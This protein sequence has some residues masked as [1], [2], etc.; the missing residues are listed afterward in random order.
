MG[1]PPNGSHRRRGRPQLSRSG[2]TPRHARLPRSLLRRTQR[3]RVLAV[4]LGLCAGLL[5]GATA[6]AGPRFTP[7]AAGAGDPYYPLDGN[8]GYDVGHYGL[9][10]R[11]DPATD[12][13]DGTATITARATQNLSAF[14]LDLVGLTVRS[15]RVDGRPAAWQRSGQELIVT[16]S[17]GLPRGGTFTVVVRYDGIPEPTVEVFGGN[18]RVHCHR[19]RRN[20][21]GRA[22]RRR[23]L[24]PRQRPPVGQG[25]VLVR[26]RHPGRAPG[27]RERRPARTVDE[28]GLDDLAMERTR[29]DGDL[30]RDR[31][32]RGVRHP[33][34]PRG[35]RP[36]LGRHR[37]GPLPAVGSPRTGSQFAWSQASDSSFKRLAR[38]IT[39]PAGGATL[40]FWVTRY[41][42]PEWDFLFVEAH[43]AGLD[44][45]TTLPDLNG[46][47]SDD[48]GFSCPFGGWQAI[49]PFL[50][51][52]QSDNGDGT[53]SPSG[54]SGTW[55]AATGTGDGSENWVVDLSA[56]AGSDVEVSISYASDEVVQAQGVFVDDI[57][58]STGEGSTSFEPGADP[59]AG[60]Q[61]AG[62]P[63]GS[64]GNDNDWIVGNAAL[65]PPTFGENARA[66]FARQPEMLAFLS[67]QF[68]PYPWSVGGGI[69]DGVEGLGFALETQTRPI[70]SK[71]F[72]DAPGSGDSGVLHENAHQWY[73]D[74]VALERWRDVW[75]NEGFATYAE[76]LWGDHEGQGT[77][78]DTFDFFYSVIPDDDPFW[79]VTIGDPGAGSE[80][81]VRGLRPGGDDAP[82]PPPGSRRHAVLP[83]PAPLG[84]HA[85]RWPRHHRPVHRSGRAD[86]RPGSRRPVRHLAVHAVEAGARGRRRSGLGIRGPDGAPRTG[87]RAES[88]CSAT[89]ATSWSGCRAEVQGVAA[90]LRDA[91]WRRAGGRSRRPSVR[92]AA[93]PA[94]SRLVADI[95][96]RRRDRSPRAGRGAVVDSYLD[97][98]AR[99][100]SPATDRLR[101]AGR[102]PD[103]G[104]RG[105]PG[106]AGRRR[107]T[108]GADRAPHAVRRALR[109]VDRGEPEPQPAAALVPAER[110]GNA[111]R[112]PAE[113]YR[114]PLC[115]G[116]PELAFSYEAAVF[117]NRFPSFVPDPPAVP[118]PPTRGWRRRSGSARSSCSPSATRATSRRSPR[119]RRPGSS[120][121]W[122]DRT[123][124]LWADARNAFVM[125]FESR[126]AE[127]GATL[128]HPHGQIYA[129][130]HLPPQMERAGGGARRRAGSDGRLRDVRRRRR[131][132]REPPDHPPDG[133]WVVGVP[134]APR[135]PYEVHIRAVRHGLRRLTDL[136]P[137]EARVARR[138]PPRRGRTLQRAVRLRA[139]VHDDRARGTAGRRGLAPRG[140]VLPA[141]P[142]RKAHQGPGVGRDGD[143]PLHQR[144][145]ARGERRPPRRPARSRRSRITRAT[146]SPRATTRDDARRSRGAPDPALAPRRSATRCGPSSR[147]PRPTR[148]AIRLVRAPG[149]VNLIGEHTDYNLGFVLPPPSTSRSGSPSSRPR[150]GGS[151]SSALDR[152]AARLRPRRARPA[153]RRV[154]RLRR[155][156]GLGAR[157]RPA[158]RP[159]ACAA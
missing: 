131:P 105:G 157:P 74:S 13:L 85:R 86:L 11:Y 57:A 153:D 89:A 143:A 20:H 122:T 154:D 120:A 30:P 103:P 106:G 149:R 27:G 25:I 156:H 117:D 59:L 78:Q 42:E 95:A 38:T 62:P 73:G 2:S 46:H 69:V 41:T 151:S 65:G 18:L 121:V 99:P 55:S 110:L 53:C 136:R 115:P 6:A 9:R 108:L 124:D 34:L 52:Y 50:A 28:A 142:V 132:A 111:P 79:A 54:T 148:S 126:G 150:T 81:D 80:F 60:W 40:S 7:G 100:A 90:A 101:P 113:R 77:P 94:L 152:R 58:V 145:A 39:V 102:P 43:T 14:D 24:V 4:V 36:V 15:V 19:R 8:G 72:F 71:D 123:R 112:Q 109:L 76:W 87:G 130:N 67:S 21:R 158:S 37:P 88:S 82:G 26:H 114:C 10:L 129:F 17:R 45:W 141:P 144:H 92:S 98:G 22:A 44:D 63:P 5:P 35:R 146:S 135:W 91:W 49:H 104:L 155:R 128:S 66:S 29:P 61:V 116:G 139:P 47:T 56:Y 138:R 119:S 68:G 118:I 70:Y 83:H 107:A 133:H 33:C 147:P 93:A 32:R 127:V 75:L 51:R 125:P 137:D 3:A 159:T 23:D 12:V 16:P 97:D 96:R 84:E 1:G 64:P 31:Q 134:F 48:T 140:R